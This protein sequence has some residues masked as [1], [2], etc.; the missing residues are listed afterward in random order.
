[1]SQETRKDTRAKIVSLN[2]KYKSATVDEFIENHSHDVSKGGVF[3]KTATPFPPGTLLKFEIRIAGDQAVIG[4]VGR[5]VWKREG[6]QTSAESPGGMGVKFIKLDDASRANIE[7]LVRGRDDAG[8]AFEAGIANVPR[9]IGNETPTMPPPGDAPAPAVRIPP[10]AV[11]P[12]AR[13]GTMIGIGKGPALTPAAPPVSP[14]VAPAMRAKPAIPPVAAPPVSPPQA[15]VPPVPRPAPSSP[16]AVAKEAPVEGLSASFFPKTESQ[17]EMP[18]QNERT[19]MRQA[20]DLLDEALKAAGGSLDELGRDPLFDEEP[21]TLLKASEVEPPTT[22]TDEALTQRVEPI[23]EPPP[24]PVPVAS[25]PPPPP[26]PMPRE[27]ARRAVSG[28]PPAKSSKSGWVVPVVVLGA[29]V[30]GFVVWTKMTTPP[31][32]VQPV[33]TVPLP[34]SPPVPSASTAASAAP[35]SAS[36]AAASGAPSAATSASAAPADSAS[37]APSA[38]ASAS[39]APSASA[40]AAPPPRRPRPPRPPPPPAAT[41]Q[42]PTDTPAPTTAPEP[43]PTPPA[44]PDELK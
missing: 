39:A 21:K 29:A 9:P 10:A 30:V 25:E 23:S 31:P 28:P 19:M 7:R 18:P 26:I 43:K 42:A 36:S 2:V 22:K 35:S 17:K 37:P 40:A 41:D 11:V 32:A 3:I 24:S 20:S 1:M 34:S 15:G 27:S 33:A 6:A 16:Q 44:N 14:P 13:K 4:G 12:A 8:S 5:V 38:G